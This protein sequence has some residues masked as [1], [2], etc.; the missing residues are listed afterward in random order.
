MNNV[1]IILPAN[2][3]NFRI[4][5]SNL[6]RHVYVVW[7]AASC[8]FLWNTK[9]AKIEKCKQLNKQGNKQINHSELITEIINTDADKRK[10]ENRDI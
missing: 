9:A 3:K 6:T 1:K 10:K 5:L 4:M 2:H 8:I 7:W